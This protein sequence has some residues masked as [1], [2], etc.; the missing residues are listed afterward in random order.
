MTKKILLACLLLIIFIL[1][2]SVIRQE[3]Q[4]ENKRNAT[5]PQIL[6]KEY[7][8]DFTGV[9]GSGLPDG[10]IK[11]KAGESKYAERSAPIPVI[12]PLDLKTESIKVSNLDDYFSNRSETAN[13]PI[14]ADVDRD[15]EKE[16]IVL[17][18]NEGGNHPYHSGYILKNGQIILHIPLNNGTIEPSTDGNGFYAKTVPLEDKFLKLG[19]CCSAGYRIY[20]VIFEQGKFKPVWEQNVFYLRVAD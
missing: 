11:Y 5:S 4:K 20:R 9:W 3:K 19:A 14:L 8:D 13:K 6:L 7:F 10:R 1:G 2:I 12:H 16:Q 17:T 18:A 15:G